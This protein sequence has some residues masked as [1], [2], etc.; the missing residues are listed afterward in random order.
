K[1]KVCNTSI[2]GSNPGGTSLKSLDFRLFFSYIY[3]HF[4]KDSAESDQAFKKGSGCR[5][6]RKNIDCVI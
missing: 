2:P 3:I 5:A 1:A 4:Y 6:L